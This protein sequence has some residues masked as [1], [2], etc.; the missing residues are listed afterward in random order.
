MFLLQSSWKGDKQ[1]GKNSRKKGVFLNNMP[2]EV[3][4]GNKGISCHLFNLVIDHVCALFMFGFRTPFGSSL[5]LCS[6]CRPEF[7]MWVWNHLLAFMCAI[8]LCSLSE[9]FARACW[10]Q[11]DTSSIYSEFSQLN[12]LAFTWG[13]RKSKNETW[14][15]SGSAVL[16]C[17]T[18]PIVFPFLRPCMQGKI[19]LIIPT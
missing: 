3:L 16:I 10:V 8:T 18:L 1:D 19:N 17:S 7:Q 14:I 9:V 15:C 4:H 5:L 6:T 13:S 11:A 2:P 12:Y